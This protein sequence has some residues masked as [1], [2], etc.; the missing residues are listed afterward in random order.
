MALSLPNPYM[1]YFQVCFFLFY[2]KPY[3][4]GAFQKKGF[5]CTTGDFTAT[6]VVESHTGHK[7]PL[8]NWGGVVLCI[9]Y[10]PGVCTTP[11]SNVLLPLRHASLMHRNPKRHKVICGM[12]PSGYTNA[13]VPSSS[14]C[15][16]YVIAP[17]GFWP[18]GQTPRRQN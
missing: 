5:H 3:Y 11:S 7:G 13:N 8:G 15:P 2:R 9:S 10:I 1:F 17:A 14:K 6:L 16:I 18:R 4:S 12:R